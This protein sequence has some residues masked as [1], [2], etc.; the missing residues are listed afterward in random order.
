MKRIF[1]SLVIVAGFA[2]LG[3]M[4]IQAQQVESSEIETTRQSVQS[5]YVDADNDGVCDNYDGERAGKGLGPGNGNGLGRSEG[6]G[7][8]R[9]KGL[10]DGS[11]QGMR[12][13]RGRAR[14]DGSCRGYGNVQNLQDNS[15]QIPEE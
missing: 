10:R 7:L 9:G 3:S 6:K 12:D 4:E 11:G 1:L 5:G 8:G 13:G 2:F 14:R 15:S